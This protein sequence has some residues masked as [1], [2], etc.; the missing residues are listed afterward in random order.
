M[1][2]VGVNEWIEVR[3]WRGA[4]VGVGA[5]VAVGVAVRVGA[6]E[7]RIGVLE[8]SSV[9]RCSSWRLTGDGR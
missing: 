4:G 1:G 6:E 9:V 3:G 2:V 5:G 8:K 7:S